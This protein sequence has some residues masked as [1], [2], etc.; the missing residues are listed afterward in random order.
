GAIGS[1]G[2]DRGSKSR[3]RQPAAVQ[4]RCGRHGA[5]RPRS[6]GCGGAAVSYGPGSAARR[7]RNDRSGGALHRKAIASLPQCLRPIHHRGVD[8]YRRTAGHRRHAKPSLHIA[9]LSDRGAD[10]P[11]HGFPGDERPRACEDLARDRHSARHARGPERRAIWPGKVA[12]IES[13]YRAGA[14]VTQ[15]ISSRLAKSS[16]PFVVDRFSLPE[17]TVDTLLKTPTVTVRDVYCQGSFAH[18]SA[19]EHATA[20]QLVFPY[21]GVY[22]RHLGRDEAVGEANQ[23]LFFNAAEGNRV[24]HPA[25]GGDASLTLILS[26][27]HMAELVPRTL[28][29]DRAPLAFRRQRLRIDA[30]AQAL[31]ALLRHSLRENVAEPLEA[32]CLALTLAQ[33]ALGPRT[34]HVPGASAGRQRLVDRAKLVMA[35]DLARRWTLADIAAEVRGGSPVYLTQGFQ[36]VEGLPLYRYQLRLRLARSLDLL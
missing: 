17:F 33:R 27:P 8:V 28:L 4:T 9:H 23:G 7:F 32:E 18:A 14:H 20:T 16:P 29:C 3:R 22:V 2:H 13:R 5:L 1:G 15:S 30:P 31:I 25:P 26:E 36:Q 21:R 24:S 12:A 10:R 11:L 34:T 35:T 6:G 19:E